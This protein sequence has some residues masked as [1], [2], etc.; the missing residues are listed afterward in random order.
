MSKENKQDLDLLDDH[1]KSK[2]EPKKQEP[3]SEVRQND[4]ETN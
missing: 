1:E 3:K 2:P 4:L